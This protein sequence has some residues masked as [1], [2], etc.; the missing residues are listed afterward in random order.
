MVLWGAWGERWTKILGS[1]EL[2]MDERPDHPR[3]DRF[4]TQ[5]S[6]LNAETMALSLYLNKRISTGKTQYVR[7]INEDG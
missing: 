1:G 5:R 4:L 6:P 2:K 7:Q 3:G